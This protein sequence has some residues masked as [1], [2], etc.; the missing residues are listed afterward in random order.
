M[1]MISNI[2]DKIETG[3]DKMFRHEF[4]KTLF[5][6]TYHLIDEFGE[7]DVPFRLERYR[8]ID[9]GTRYLCSASDISSMS[10]NV[11]DALD[12]V[13]EHLYNDSPRYYRL[14]E[15]YCKLN[16]II[17]S[18]TIYISISKEEIDNNIGTI[19]EYFAATDPKDINSA[20]ATKLFN[21]I[22][23]YIPNEYYDN[24]LKHSIA[25]LDAQARTGV[26]KVKRNAINEIRN[27]ISFLSIY[28]TFVK[29]DVAASACRSQ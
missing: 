27:F 10:K 28:S 12:L 6:K 17:N 26:A 21:N 23:K 2:L 7:Y 3:L 1:N 9:H 24:I 20:D 29:F 14:K 16:N 25:D 18:D 5:S 4:K 11:Y 13:I 15:N 8:S 22:L 19:M